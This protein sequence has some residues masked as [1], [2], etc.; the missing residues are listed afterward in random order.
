MTK[1]RYYR[2]APEYWDARTCERKAKHTAKDGLGTKYPF[3][4][5]IGNHYGKTRFNGGC[6]RNDKWYEGQVI[7]LPV[8]APGF[9]LVHKLT[10]GWQIVKTDT[11]EEDGLSM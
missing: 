3:K 2:P 10:W 8:I 7:P 9:K 5:Y 11:G 4:G 1:A 6:I